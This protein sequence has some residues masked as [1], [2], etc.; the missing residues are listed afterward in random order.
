M[1]RG[2]GTVPAVAIPSAGPSA[3]DLACTPVPHYVLGMSRGPIATIAALLFV[4]VYV[5]A[6]T[7]LPDLF[8]RMHWA[9]EAVYWLVAGVVWVYPVTRLMYWAAGK[10]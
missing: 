10:R 9:V 6:V 8:P 1:P 4:A 7:S 2:K 3:L 5:M